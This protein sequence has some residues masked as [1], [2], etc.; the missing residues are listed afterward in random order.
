M[1]QPTLYAR[2][3]TFPC[4]SR[5]YLIEIHGYLILFV[6]SLSVVLTSSSPQ[7]TLPG[8]SIKVTEVRLSIQLRIQA[9]FAMTFK[10]FLSRL[11]MLQVDFCL[12][13]RH[14]FAVEKLKKANGMSQMIATPFFQSHHQFK[15]GTLWTPS[16]PPQSM[17]RKSRC[18]KSARMQTVSL[19]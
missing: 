17:S 13:T 8:Q 3:G 18:A 6:Q 9:W 1:C 19:S 2:S 12:V 16:S 5:A 11:A 10:T 14:S 7:E 15:R 4:H